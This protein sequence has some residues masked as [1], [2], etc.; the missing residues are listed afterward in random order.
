MH[1][2]LTSC[3]VENAETIGLRERQEKTVALVNVH[4]ND[5]KL[6]EAE[7]VI[8]LQVVLV[9]DFDL[10]VLLAQHDVVLACL[11]FVCY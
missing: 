3:K 11:D 5:W 10:T 8:A 4:V 7:R 9:N 2:Q 1:N 6:R